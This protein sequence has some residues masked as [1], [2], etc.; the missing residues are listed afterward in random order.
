MNV[1]IKYP[2]QGIFGASDLIR[3]YLIITTGRSK[4]KL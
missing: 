4:K 3:S 1:E 2:A